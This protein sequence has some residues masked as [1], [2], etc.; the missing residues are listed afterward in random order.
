MQREIVFAHSLLQS[1]L[2]EREGALNAKDGESGDLL[3]NC[4][5][6]R[7]VWSRVSEGGT[8]AVYAVI[9]LL[10][11]VVIV[12]L[13]AVTNSLIYGTISPL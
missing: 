7:R 4:R 10:L 1:G 2:E 12:S 13:Q 6:S 11:C 3:R 9:I 5:H 8:E